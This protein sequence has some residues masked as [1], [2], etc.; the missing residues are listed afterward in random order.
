MWRTSKPGTCRRVRP[1]HPSRPSPEGTRR[2]CGGAACAAITPEPLER[3]ALLSAGDLDPTFGGGDGITLTG[4][5]GTEVAYDVALLPGG[6]IVVGATGGVVR[7][8]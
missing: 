8:N 4:F 5:G 1:F 2:A 3:R 6:K 7:Y